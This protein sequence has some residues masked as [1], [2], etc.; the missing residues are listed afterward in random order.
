MKV[1][2]FSLFVVFI[3]SLQAVPSFSQDSTKV[4][5]LPTG[6]EIRLSASVDQ[7]QVPLNR[8]VSFTVQL[9][10]TGD[11]DKYE[12]H[13]F[14]N[15]LL[16]NFEIVENSSANRVANVNGETRA[17]QEYEYTL[18]PK[19][20]GMGYVE[21][22]II[23]YT[24]MGNDKE[25]RLT[26]NRIDVKVTDPLP[27]PGS[28]SWILWVI[29]I[30]VLVIVV[31]IFIRQAAKKKAEKKRQAELEAAASVPLEEQY[32]EKLKDA[33][34]LSSPDLNVGDGFARLS[35]LLRLFLA[36]KFHV[37]G[38]EATTEDVI[39]ELHNKD[40][41]DRFVNET[42]E[43]LKKA[44]LIKFSG[45]AGEKSDLERMYTLIESS[46]QKSLR[47]ELVK[48]LDTPQ[49]ETEEK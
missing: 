28:K 23:T 11:L 13:Q 2:R 24:D 27:E 4:A 45:G 21:G 46:L 25:Y 5:A 15:P 43:S 26:T 41:D 29:L 36:E 38:L 47:G 48:V 34:D 12:I 44:D 7:T 3:L 49:E 1:L 31:V 17:I 35:R 16:E 14:D 20:L 18:K 37:A 32:L 9:Q 8:T 10:W 30:F 39:T 33:V 22:L 42:A 40:L 19:S 6:G